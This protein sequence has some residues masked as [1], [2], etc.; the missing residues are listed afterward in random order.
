VAAYSYVFTG[1]GALV[2]L[3]TSLACFGLYVHA[4]LVLK[5]PLLEYV[6]IGTFVFR[7]FYRLD[8][9]GLTQEFKTRYFQLLQEYRNKPIDLKEICLDLSNYKTRKNLDSIQDMN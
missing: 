8:N 7:S 4:F 3:V 2:W 6:L 1:S 9:A 5:H